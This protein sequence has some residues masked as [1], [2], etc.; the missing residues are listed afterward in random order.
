MYGTAV[1]DWGTIPFYL[2]R[3]LNAGSKDCV[4]VS[5]FG[6]EGYVTDQEVILLTELLKAGEHP[7]IVIFYDG[8][9]DSLMAWSPSGPPNPHFMF[10]DVKKRVEGSL[11]GR[12]DFL[13]KSYTVRAAQGGFD[14]SPF[15]RAVPVPHCKGATERSDNVRE[16]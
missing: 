3:D 13:Q 16:L 7:D 10:G 9:N 5:N 1:P 8:V 2:S 14:T 11:S 4:F 6:V 15:A 12:L